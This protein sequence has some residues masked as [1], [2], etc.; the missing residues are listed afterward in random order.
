MIGE[1]P[2]LVESGDRDARGAELDLATGDLHT[3]VSLYVRTE[4][5]AQ[6]PSLSGHRREIRLQTLTIDEQARSWKIED[7]RHTSLPIARRQAES[8]TRKA[9]DDDQGQKRHQEAPDRARPVRS[10]SR[11]RLHADNRQEGDGASPEAVAAPWTVGMAR[12]LDVAGGGAAS[13][14]RSTA[15][16]EDQVAKIEIDQACPGDG[17]AEKTDPRSFAR[18]HPQ[19][20]IATRVLLSV[21]REMTRPIDFS[22]G[23]TDPASF[24]VDELAQAAGDGIRAIG[25]NFVFYPGPLGHAGLRRILADR[26]SQREGVEVDPDHLALTNGSM[27][28]V[29]LVGR[30]L[31]K[32]P[33]DVIVTEEL[34]YPGTIAA[35]KGIGA[36]LVGVPVDNQGM[37]TDLLAATLENLRRTGDEARFIYTLPTYQNPTAAVMPLERREELLDVANRFEI[38]VVED[39]CYADVH[40]DGEVPPSL[41]TLKGG[42]NVIYLCSLSKIFAAGLRIGYL[43]ARPPMLEHLTSRRFDAGHS[44]LAASVAAAY[45]D[46]GE[47]WRHVEEHN[48][49]LRKKRDALLE[50]LDQHLEG[51]CTWLAPI[52]GLFL[53]LGLPPDTDLDLLERRAGEHDVL[54][55]RGAHFHI[56]GADLPWLRLAFGY[57]TV[58]EIQRGIPLLADSINEAQAGA[59]A[60]AGS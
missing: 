13:P 3:L 33:G 19:Q 26:E 4:C 21:P 16:F 48:A 38:Q 15:T 57:P 18:A 37:R 28:A 47:L 36:R 52:G 34:T 23:L 24:P 2:G 12:H 41:Y 1:H 55:V 35:Y 31:M 30:A 49:A 11:D 58:A 8:N 9:S 45:L 25:E 7:R 6:C 42:E 51:I 22:T 54:F 14:D 60:A 59:E 29:T 20:S 46:D 10:Q 53:W 50:S 40:F 27:Q 56:D 43:Y 39:N 44:V 32:A 5:H 17:Q